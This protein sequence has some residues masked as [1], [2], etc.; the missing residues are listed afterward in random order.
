[1]VSL[2]PHWYNITFKN[3]LIKMINELCKAY[4]RK[5]HG[6]T[7]RQEG[8]LQSTVAIV[9]SGYMSR[10]EFGLGYLSK[11]QLSVISLTV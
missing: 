11:R 6:G 8:N 1:M 4:K 9:S 7:L 3:S 5:D 10:V 2:H